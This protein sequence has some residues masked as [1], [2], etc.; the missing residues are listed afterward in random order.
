MCKSPSI[1]ECS[2]SISNKKTYEDGKSMPNNDVPEGS[3]TT[4]NVDKGS[5]VSNGNSSLPCG[6]ALPNSIEQRLSKQ[7]IESKD[8][9][10]ENKRT[11]IVTIESD[12]EAQRNDSTCK[13]VKLADQSDLK[14][15][16]GDSVAD[17]LPS[18]NG[19]EKFHCTSCNKLT[20]EVHSHPLLKVIICGDCRSVMKKKM[21]VKVLFDFICFCFICDF[22]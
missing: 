20:V 11:R 18:Q 2:A 1:L 9:D 22:Y 14:E 12:D 6:S 7:Q 21:Q 16:N 17:S 3:E 4:D 13:R 15:N 5:S 10:I 19:T 8:L